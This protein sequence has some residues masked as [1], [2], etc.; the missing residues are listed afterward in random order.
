MRTYSAPSAPL[1]LVRKKAN[2]NRKY[3]LDTHFFHQINTESKAYWLG[4][5]VAD[6]YLCRAGMSGSSLRIKLN[7]KDANHLEKFKLALNSNQPIYYSEP[8]DKRTGKTYKSAMLEINSCELFDD[9]VGLNPKSIDV[10]SHVPKALI[11]HFIRGLFD[12]DGSLYIQ[13]KKYNKFGLTYTDSDRN[14]I[15]YVFDTFKRISKSRS[16]C[17]WSVKGKFYEFILTGNLQLLSILNWLYKDST[18]SLDRKMALY[19]KLKGRYEVRMQ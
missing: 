13:N 3:T 8:Y 9:L 16:S 6:G 15:Y 5:V 4:F 10:V 1:V 17:I 11:H 14:L 7:S 12:G 19:L 18:I 2:I